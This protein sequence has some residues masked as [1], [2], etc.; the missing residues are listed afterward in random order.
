MRIFGRHYRVPG[1]LD[2][3]RPFPTQDLSGSLPGQLL[4]SLRG[5][6]YPRSRLTE[7]PSRLPVPG[8]SPLHPLPWTAHSGGSNPPSLSRPSRSATPTMYAAQSNFPKHHLSPR[9]ESLRPPPS[10]CQGARQLAIPPRPPAPQLACSALPH[11]PSRVLYLLTCLPFY[12]Y[13]WDPSRKL[14][15][16]NKITNIRFNFTK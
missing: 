5:S 12:P 10:T 7:G 4:P 14:C 2:Q 13:R 9:L 3:A 8:T 16:L 15:M 1:G 6:S 11:P